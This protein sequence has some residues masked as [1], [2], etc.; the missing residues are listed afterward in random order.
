MKINYTL[1]DYLVECYYLKLVHFTF[2]K[3]KFHM[4]LAKLKHSMSMNFFTFE[5]KNLYLTIF[6]GIH[7]LIIGTKSKTLQRGEG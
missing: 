4:T 2:S 3:I 6:K 5:T 1:K 7:V